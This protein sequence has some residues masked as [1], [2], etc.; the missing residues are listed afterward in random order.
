LQKG[1]WITTNCLF[2]ILDDRST[3][4]KSARTRICLHSWPNPWKSHA[5]FL[6]KG[7]YNVYNV[8]TLYTLC[9]HCIHCIHTMYT[10]MSI[11]CIH[12]VHIVNIQCIQCVYNVYSNVYTL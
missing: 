3:D 10:V 4:L 11:H 1:T 8:Y 2:L 6:Y 9:T 7:M 5:K 12:C